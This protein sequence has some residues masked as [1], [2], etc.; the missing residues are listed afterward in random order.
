MNDFS[1]PAK[2]YWRE[3]SDFGKLIDCKIPQTRSSGA[4]GRWGECIARNFLL[5]N[6]IL[7]VRHAVFHVSN[8]RLISDLFHPSSQTACEVKTGR[9]TVDPYFRGY[10]GLFSQLLNQGSVRRVVYVHVCFGG[11]AGFSQ[12]QSSAI[13]DAGFEILTIED[14]SGGSSHAGPSGILW[15]QADKKSRSPSTATGF[16]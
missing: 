9:R 6:G 14:Q 10:V 16:K 2:A 7:T 8:R 3:D 11:S 1:S 4:I 13:R 5:S 15:N 12:S